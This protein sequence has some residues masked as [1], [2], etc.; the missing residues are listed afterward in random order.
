M[1]K[2]NTSPLPR[3][4]A[5]VT[6]TAFHSDPVKFKRFLDLVIELS[7]D[8]KRNMTSVGVKHV[9]ALR[10]EFKNE[11]ELKLPQATTRLTLDDIKCIFV[12][13]TAEARFIN[14]RIAESGF[15]Y[16]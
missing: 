3:T 7:A 14:E 8:V 1:K 10:N 2:H 11:T 5:P 13:R 9:N 4:E 16:V 12:F 6:V 15:N